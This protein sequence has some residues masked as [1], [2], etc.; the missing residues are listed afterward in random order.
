MKTKTKH[1]HMDDVIFVVNEMSFEG[2]GIKYETFGEGRIPGIPP[3]VIITSRRMD[4]A[5]TDLTVYLY[6]KKARVSIYRDWA[7]DTV[8]LGKLAYGKNFRADLRALIQRVDDA[9]DG[10]ARD[11]IES[12]T[13]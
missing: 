2:A 4:A 1:D 3:H 10:F 7:A 5:T 6:A 11:A 8:P 12:L 9:L 13:N